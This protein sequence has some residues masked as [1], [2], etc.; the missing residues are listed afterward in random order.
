MTATSSNASAVPLA[1]TA[2][3][4]HATAKAIEEPTAISHGS[5]ASLTSQTSTSEPNRKEKEALNAGQAFTIIEVYMSLIS[6]LSW[7]LSHH[8]VKGGEWIQVGCSACIDVRTL[9][10]DLD[11]SELQ[12]WITTTTKLCYDIKWLSSGLLL[13]S[14]F[15]VRLPRY[16]RMSKM[17]SRGGQ[18]TGLVVG[19]PILLSPSGIRC[20]YLGTEDI[21]KSDVQRRSSAKVKASIVSRLAHYGIR[22]APEVIWIQAHK[23]FESNVSDG[24][25]VTLWPADLCLCED[26][27]DSVSGGDSEPL[28]SPIV[29]GSVDPLEKAESWLLGKAARLQALRAKTQEEDH[30]VSVSKDAED[31]DDED[32]FSPF[33]VL[34]D[35]GI[36]PQDVSGIYPTPPDGLPLAIIGSSDPN[37]PQ[38]G[39]FDDEEKELQPSDEARGE[40]DG[41]ENDDLFGDMD[42]DMFASNGLTEADFSFF[43]EPDMIDEAL[44]EPDQA[45]TSGGTNELTDHPMALDGQDLTATPKGRGDSGSDQNAM[46][47]QED[48][49]HA[50]GMIP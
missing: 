43:D 11:D 26:M 33:E 24:Q 35:Q 19:S 23:G 18:S 8:M 4:T 27:I 14:F 1:R 48:R 6:A 13:I 37:N 21:P 38:L 41:Q 2:R 12:P 36:S 49:I 32:D 29:D 50:Q 10:D 42:I 22:P 47:D 7:S 16:I 9:G 45:I 5:N 39:D 44:R 40:Y 34:M 28:N 15:K 30:K 20:R 31:T 25:P 3:S 46:D 17:L